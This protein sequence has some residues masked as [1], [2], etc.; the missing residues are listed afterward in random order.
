M[1]KQAKENLEI[2]KKLLR[3]QY[4]DQMYSI[5]NNLNNQI[6]AD[7]HMMTYNL[8][9]IKHMLNDNDIE[10]IWKVLKTDVQL[11]MYFLPFYNLITRN[12]K[13]ISTIDIRYINT[14]LD[15]KFTR[16]DLNPFRR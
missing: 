11:Q 10:E 16:K 3:I 4:Q 12:K 9:K 13:I 1:H 6:N 14:Y 8:L 5:V 15:E 2:N 7:K